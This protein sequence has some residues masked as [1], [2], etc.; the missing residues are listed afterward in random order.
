M[1]R[2]ITAWAVVDDGTVVLK[3]TGGL[4]DPPH[5]W[6]IGDWFAND[7][8]ETA[9]Q[10]VAIWG[11]DCLYWH[12]DDYGVWSE[13]ATLTEHDKPCDPPAWFTEDGAS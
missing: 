9:C 10:I 12:Q 7:D 8:D 11:T 4:P 3:L 2:T 13:W 5:E 1:S 6:K